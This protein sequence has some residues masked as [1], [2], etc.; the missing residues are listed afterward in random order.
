MR[1]LL[2]NK[3]DIN[4]QNHGMNTPLHYAALADHEAAAALLVAAGAGL[5]ITD[6][7]GRTPLIVCAREDGGAGTAKILLEAGAD[8]SAKDIHDDD[9]LMLAAWRGKKDVVDLL[10][11]A[12]GAVPK[13]GPDSRTLFRYAAENGLTRLFKNLVTAGGDPVF[14]LD[15]GGTLAHLAAAGGSLEI[16]RGLAA[17]GLDIDARDDNGWTPLHYAARDG[18]VECVRW[19]C[20]EK[21]EIDARTLQGQTAYNIALERGMSQTVETLR[22]A[23]ADMGPMQFPEI[24]GPYLGLKPPGGTP[25]VFA[26]GI[27]SSVW[28]L[29]SSVAFSPDGRTAL[30]SPMEG[31]PG[32]VYSRSNIMM[33]RMQ[34]DRWAPPEWAP[35]TSE[36]RGDVA[37][38]APDGSRIYFLSRRTL[39]D[40]EPSQRERIWFADRAGDTWGPA[41]LVDPIVND[42]PQHWQ[43]SV[44]AAHTIYFTADL[45]E[46]RGGRRYLPGD[47]CRR[48]LA[49]TGEPRF[50]YQLRQG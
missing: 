49:A 36:D 4:V 23:G 8:V 40:E 44:D 13:K 27:V 30:W 2:D 22:A 15:S 43:F 17:R 21:T 37:F 47:P 16:L 45:P 19:L 18:R 33:L 46:G 11:D 5:E 25:R 35:F 41:Q 6:D 3:A 24:R 9:A 14:I 10:L 12:G 20:G 34:G 48:Q 28:S 50:E 31:W 38:F 42:Y 29:H 39:P 32:E 7:Y 26:R 1:V